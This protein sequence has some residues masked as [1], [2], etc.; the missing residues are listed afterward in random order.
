MP[1]VESD[2]TGVPYLQEGVDFNRFKLAKDEPRIV[3]IGDYISIHKSWQNKTSYPEV[4]DSKLNH[5]FEIINTGAVFYSLPEE[6]NLLKNKALD[7]SPDVIVWGFV[8]NDF[9]FKNPRNGI[10]PLKLKNSIFGLKPITPLAIEHL[11][12]LKKQSNISKMYEDK[13]RISKGFATVYTNE[14]ARNYL[15]KTFIWLKKVEEEKKAEIIFVIIPPFY[16]FGDE[17]VNYMNNWVY[18]ECLKAELTCISML[19]IFKKYDVSDVKEDDNDIWHQNSFGN[20]LIAAEI[21]KS[22]ISDVTFENFIDSI[23]C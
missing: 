10:V 5:S 18:E 22:M 3:I 1:F 16:D 8:F 20:D 19:D 12:I 4:L 21:C 6:V 23:K 9:Y 17:N 14:T 2:I 7:Y 15:E 13:Q 11:Q